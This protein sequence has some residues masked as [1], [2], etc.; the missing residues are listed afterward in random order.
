MVSR[1]CL[2][3]DPVFISER[4][5]QDAELAKICPVKAIEGEKKQSHTVLAD[6]CSKCG[7]CKDVCKSDAVIVQ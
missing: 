4:T 3:P 7:S 2:H 1:G 5:A 6:L